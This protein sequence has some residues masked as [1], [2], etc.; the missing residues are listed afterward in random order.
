MSVIARSISLSIQMQVGGVT[1]IIVKN[2]WFMKISF[3]EPEGAMDC[4]KR[5]Q[6]YRLEVCLSTLF[7]CCIFVHVFRHVF[8]CGTHFV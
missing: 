4:A 8:S 6:T 1:K 3:Q 7:T 5:T 2:N